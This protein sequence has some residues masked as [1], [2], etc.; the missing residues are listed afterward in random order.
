MAMPLPTR[1]IALVQSLLV[2]SLLASLVESVDQPP[3]TAM[4]YCLSPQRRRELREGT[5]SAELGR[6]VRVARLDTPLPHCFPAVYLVGLNWTPLKPGH[7]RSRE[8]RPL[9][10]PPCGFRC[11]PWDSAVRKHPSHRPPRSPNNLTTK[12]DH[13]VGLLS[14]KQKFPVSLPLPNVFQNTLVSDDV[15]SEI[16]MAGEHPLREK[17]R[18]PAT[19]LCTAPTYRTELRLVV[20]RRIW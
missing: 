5:D 12:S 13:S 7:T 1:S 4:K 3:R 16:R 2:Q 9:S 11:L 20:K 17:R 8:L 14:N 18:R 6:S 19:V 15:S 10:P